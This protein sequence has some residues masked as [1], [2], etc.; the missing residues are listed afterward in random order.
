M[1]GAKLEHR[2]VKRGTAAI[3]HPHVLVM[4]THTKL[5]LVDWVCMDAVQ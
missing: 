3:I 5:L 1:S 4:T 2:K